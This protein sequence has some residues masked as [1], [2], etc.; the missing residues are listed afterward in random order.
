MRTPSPP[1]SRSRRARSHGGRLV[2]WG[3]LEFYRREGYVDEKP[4]PFDI[5][6]GVLIDFVRMSKML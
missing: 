6:G 4:V 5:G 3:G 1:S 2:G